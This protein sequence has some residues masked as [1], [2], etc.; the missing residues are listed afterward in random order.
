MGSRMFG[1]STSQSDKTRAT[2]NWRLQSPKPSVPA[3]EHRSGHVAIVKWIQIPPHSSRQIFEMACRSSHSGHLRRERRRRLHIRLGTTFR[4]TSHNNYG[5]RLA[6]FLFHLQTARQD[7]GNRVFND[8][9]L[10]SAVERTRRTI[11]PPHEGKSYRL[12]GRITRPV[13]L[14]TPVH[15]VGHSNHRQAGFRSLASRPRFWRGP[16][17]PWRGASLKSRHGSR[18]NPAKSI[19]SRR[20]ARRGVPSS[21]EAN[22][23]TSASSNSSSAGS[24]VMHARLRQTWWCTVVVSIPLRGS[25]PR[26]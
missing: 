2:A 13:V 19:R 10:S 12:R 24:S 14:E 6:V 1:L 3:R 18:I 25:I 9:S 8:D 7:V 20:V 4:S 11:P 22:I 23:R 5:Q 21:A 17:H 16:C 26:H 15:H